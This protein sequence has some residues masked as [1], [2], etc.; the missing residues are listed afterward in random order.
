MSNDAQIKTCQECENA[1]VVN[2]W[3][4]IQY[5]ED[6][7]LVVITRQVVWCSLCGVSTKDSKIDVTDIK[8]AGEVFTDFFGRDGEHVFKKSRSYY[9]LPD[10]LYVKYLGVSADKSKRWTHSSS[11][12]SI[13]EEWEPSIDHI[14]YIYKSELISLVDKDKHPEELNEAAA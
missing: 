10:H 7:H 3:K 9:P 13:K 4:L 2:E 12:S 6:H 14:S 11:L 8:H 5:I 1:K